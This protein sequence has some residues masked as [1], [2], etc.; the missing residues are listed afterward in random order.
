MKKIFFFALFVLA[1]VAYGELSKKREYPPADAPTASMRNETPQPKNSSTNGRIVSDAPST[2]VG[3]RTPAVTESPQPRIMSTE[4]SKRRLE[5]FTRENREAREKER[6]E[7]KSFPYPPGIGYVLSRLG[8]FEI[9]LGILAASVFPLLAWRLRPRTGPSGRRYTEA[10]ARDSQIPSPPMEMGRPFGNPVT[11]PSA[12]PH[13]RA[14][15]SPFSNARPPIVRTVSDDG[16]VPG[17][18]I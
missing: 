4:D 12:S 16:V 13:P 18:F 3:P 5:K 14:A 10:G 1:C 7:G 2:A 17:E 6:R 8:A 9:L 15:T 11:G